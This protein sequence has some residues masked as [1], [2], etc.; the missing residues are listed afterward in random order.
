MAATAIAEKTKSK[1]MMSA[2]TLFICRSLIA[3]RQKSLMAEYQS[4]TEFARFRQLGAGPRL[5]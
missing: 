2:R 5:G 4:S 3:G 1:L